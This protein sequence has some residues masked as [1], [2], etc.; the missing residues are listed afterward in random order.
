MMREQQTILSACAGRNCIRW[1]IFFGARV[2]RGMLAFVRLPGTDENAAPSHLRAL[3]LIACIDPQHNVLFMFCKPTCKWTEG[4]GDRTDAGVARALAGA[5]RRLMFQWE[6]AAITL[7]SFLPLHSARNEGLD[8]TPLAQ[9]TPAHTCIFKAVCQPQTAPL[10]ALACVSVLPVWASAWTMTCSHRPMQ[11]E[12]SS[13]PC[14]A[15][16]PVGPL[17]GSLLARGRAVVGGPAPR[18]DLKLPATPPL[19]RAAKRAALPACR[20][21]PTRRRRRRRRRPLPLARR[22]ASLYHAPAQLHQLLLLHTVPAV[23]ARRRQDSLELRDPPRRGVS[24]RKGQGGGPCRCRRSCWRGPRRAAAACR[25]PGGAAAC[26]QAVQLPQ[27][28]GHCSAVRA[29]SSG[30]ACELWRVGGWGGV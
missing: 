11:Q 16:V 12:A 10:P 19:R 9:N 30:R 6:C 25:L 7:A 18:A 1:L 8:C 24:L 17:P 22:A 23:H 4:E 26:F 3:S 28:A 14:N 13:T 15:A 5:P 21:S 27:C 2:M 29:G 20:R